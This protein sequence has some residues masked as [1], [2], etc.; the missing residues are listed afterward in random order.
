MGNNRILFSLVLA[1]ILVAPPSLQGSPLAIHP[2]NP[3]YFTNDAGKAIYMTGS[4]AW[5]I[6]HTN[7]HVISESRI[8]AFLDWLS[9]WGHKYTRVWSGWLT[10]ANE[11]GPQGPWPYQRSGPGPARDG[12]LKFD[13]SRVD[14]SYYERLRFLMREIERRNLFCSIMLFGSAV[15]WR[16]PAYFRD[17]VAWHPENNVNSTTRSLKSARDFFKPD[18]EL[19]ELQRSHVRRMVDALNEYDNFIWEIVNEA[20]LPDSRDWQFEM[21]RYLRRYEQTKPKQHLIVMSGGNAEAGSI[22]ES[23]PADVISPDNSTDVYLQGG[24]AR[25]VGKIVVNDTDHLWGFSRPQDVERYRKWVWKSFA[26]GHHPIFMDDYDSYL[27]NNNGAINPMYDPVRRSMGDTAGF[28]ARFDDLAKMVPDET[29]SSTG[30]CLA[31]P[32]KEYFVYHPGRAEEKLNP[33]VIA[34]WLNRIRRKI[35]SR[36]GFGDESNREL[37]LEIQTGTYT[38]GWFDPRDGTR[39][40]DTLRVEA[41]S[42]HSFR[43][44]DHIQDDGVLHLKRK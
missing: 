36:A 7:G 19:L 24:P 13:F 34:G 43:L 30:Y 38:L 25:W 29:R 15:G 33:D 26:R 14:E 11:K 22:L 4:Q 17:N 39:T 20:T 27:N 42:R 16:E 12:L 37:T 41:T 2:E 32:G 23:S 5:F 31:D 9:A 40:H 35:T 8:T 1:G 21:I 18:A 28:A 10:L 44:P 3:R 6:L